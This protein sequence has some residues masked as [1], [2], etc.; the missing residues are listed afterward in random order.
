MD[1]ELH[2]TFPWTMYSIDTGFGW[3]RTCPVIEYK[4]LTDLNFHNH[5]EQHVQRQDLQQGIQTPDCSRCWYAENSGAKSYRQVLKQDIR[6]ESYNKIH[7]PVPEVLEIKFSN[8]CNLKCIFCS[9]NCSSLWEVDDPVSQDRLGNLR[10]EQV[11]KAILDFADKN[12]KDIKTFQLFGGEPV[13]HK[14]FNQIFD[15]ILSKPLSDGVKTISFSTNMY[16]NESYRLD[17]ENKIQAVLERGHKLF[18][19][20]SIDGVDEQGE[21]LRTNM[22]WKKFDKNLTSFMERFHDYPNIGRMK[23]NIALNAANIVY[24]NRIMQYLHDKKLTN[25]EPH[26]NYV[27]KPEHFY[28]KT[29]GTRLNKALDIIK[30]QDYFGY[31]GYKDHVID[32]VGSMTHLEPNIEVI[33]KG[34]QWLNTYD[35]TIG[36]SFLGLFPDNEFMFND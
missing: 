4:K 1:K 35:Q 27:H 18:M 9:S 8:L 14:E 5:K 30:S 36:K 29:Y 12:Y 20:F 11:S 15:L 13:L 2:C 10:G 22:L 32:L 7:V 6:H 21:Y 23:C 16:Y 26:Y 33:S 24:L 34:Q 31:D 17:F 19:R 28:I 25:V 3:W